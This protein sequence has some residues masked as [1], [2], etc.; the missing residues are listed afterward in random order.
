MKAG[1]PALKELRR[2]AG[3][4]AFKHTRTQLSARYRLCLTAA[5]YLG[6]CA[7][8]ERDFPSLDAEPSHEP[9]RFL[10]TYP[11]RRRQVL[12]VYEQAS[13]L[14]ITALTPHNATSEPVGVGHYVTADG[15]RR[16]A[17]GPCRPRR[18]SKYPPDWAR[19][20]EEGEHHHPDVHRHAVT[21]P[22]SPT[23]R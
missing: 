1:D 3:M 4:E 6:L 5:E 10:L 7:A 8:I 17:R 15:H 22:P 14:I 16:K 2:R 18:R 20:W 13:R 21:D 23:S 12:F 9:G 19:E 11:Y